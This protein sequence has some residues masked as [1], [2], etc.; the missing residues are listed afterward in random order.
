MQRCPSCG[1]ELPSKAL[2]CGSCRYA[3][4]QVPADISVMP[5]GSLSS[6]DTPTAISDRS[7]PTQVSGA[8]ISA[9]MD[10]LSTAVSSTSDAP[11]AI[12]NPSHPA[13]LAGVEREQTVP[14]TNDEADEEERRR[15]ALM[16]GLPL[17]G[18]LATEGQAPI[19]HVP[20]VQGT[21]QVSGV[22]MVQGT[23]SLP[24]GIAARHGSAQSA[25]HT[26]P[27]HHGTAPHHDIGSA[28]T[29]HL[30]APT[31]H[32]PRRHGCA[33]HW[34]VITFTALIIIASIM[35]GLFIFVFPPA[36]SLSGSSTVSAGNVLH[37]HGSHF[38]PDISVTLTLDDHL[39]LLFVRRGA[40]GE[41]W[42]GSGVTAA[43]QMLV[44]RPVEH[45]ISSGNAVRV[46]LGG[47]FDASIVVNQDWPAGPHTLRARESITGRSAVLRLVI[48]PKSTTFSVNP[49]NLEFGKSQADSTASQMVVVS[50]T[51]QQ[52]LN[53]TADTGGTNWLTLDMNA[54][55]LQPGAS[56]T[57]NVQ[58]DTIKLAPGDY[59]AT[60]TIKAGSEQ[61]QITITLTVTPQST[62]S[63]TP[64]PIPSPM[65]SPTLFP[66]PTPTPSPHKPTP[67]PKPSP[68]PTPT[69]SPT[70]MP[71]PMPTPTPTP[72][73]SPTP[74]PT[75]PTL[76]P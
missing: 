66:S 75:P 43:L 28:P 31:H 45:P 63:P 74:T 60:L 14:L 35:G 40:E 68:T 18:A 3:L 57:I 32:T 23:P 25:R 47:T 16:Q 34:L 15:R 2:F 70:P 73:P 26:P 54:G 48:L 65:P 64:T 22:P 72:T 38:T 17:L 50:N 37:L 19:A 61:M 21:P 44:A 36:L 7:H 67:T 39:P 6:P 52:P 9:D 69:P 71:T 53:W 33:P 49:T 4:Q 58:A 51:G 55:T 10:D 13:P 76:I 8:E 42:Y 24:G 62:P 11:T 41:A 30:Q 59:S 20:L 46:G 29:H 1:S 5:T 12:S 56:Q 27:V